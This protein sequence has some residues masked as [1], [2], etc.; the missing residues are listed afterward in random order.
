MTWTGADCW[1]NCPAGAGAD[2]VW[3][4]K[5]GKN[6]LPAGTLEVLPG[7]SELVVMREPGGMPARRRRACASLRS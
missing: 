2:L 5:N 7:G 1:R 6:C 3:R 4:W